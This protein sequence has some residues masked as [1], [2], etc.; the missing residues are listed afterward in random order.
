M[1]DTQPATVPT[2]D[3]VKVAN[4]PGLYRHARSGRYYGVKKVSGKR[5]ECSLHTHDRKIAERRLKEWMR[6]LTTVDRAVEKT[7]ASQ[8]IANLLI[9][10][11]GRSAKTRATDKSI[12]TQLQLSWPGGLDVEVR[13]VRPSHLDQWLALH[14]RRLKN[15]SYNRYAGF[16]KELFALAVHDHII[17]KSPF[18]D[19]RCGSR[20]RKSR[21]A[22]FQPS[23]NQSVR[24]GM[25][26][27]RTTTSGLC[28][29]E[30]AEHC[31]RPQRY[32]DGS[33]RCDCLQP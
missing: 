12:V 31:N 28:Q 4:F 9:T 24:L 13:D 1:N 23:N 18:D 11:L 6:T 8:L 2:S 32:D 29:K 21:S 17:A 10:T 14:E 22:L 19:V 5:R 30:R 15:T 7:T 16:L 25:T 27:T 20:R 3:Y 26:S 33:A